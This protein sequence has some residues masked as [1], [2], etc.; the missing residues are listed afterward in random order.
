MLSHG[1]FVL[2]ICFVSNLSFTNCYWHFSCENYSNTWLLQQN[3][4]CYN[5]CK[6]MPLK[7]IKCYLF[8]TLKKNCYMCCRFHFFIAMI[9]LWIVCLFAINHDIQVLLSFYKVMWRWMNLTCHFYYVHLW[10]WFKICKSLFNCLMHCITP[11]PSQLL[12]H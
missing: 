11:C 10:C 3:A 5:C 2:C 12:K 8:V 1:S 6:K 4:N 9:M 7:L